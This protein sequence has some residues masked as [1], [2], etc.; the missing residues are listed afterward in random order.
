[1]C[2]SRYTQANGTQVAG[3]TQQLYLKRALQV[4]QDKQLASNPGFLGTAL[5]GFA[6]HMAFPPHSKNDFTPTTPFVS[7]AEEDYL[8]KH[9][10]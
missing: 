2:W 9:L 8:K 3:H 1:M 7:A 10:P 4:I 6:N 5:W